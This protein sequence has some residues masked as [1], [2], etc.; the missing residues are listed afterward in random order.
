M[1][2]ENLDQLS[3]STGFFQNINA[4]SPMVTEISLVKG[5]Q[6]FIIF[7]K[8]FLKSKVYF[9]SFLGS[10]G[11]ILQLLEF[12]LEWYKNGLHTMHFYRDIAVLSRLFIRKCQ[13]CVAGCQLSKKM[14][15][16]IGKPRLAFRIDRFLP[17]YQRCISNGY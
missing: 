17:K 15:Y 14:K 11:I 1:K 8:V 5:K 2:L 6:A 16:E 12:S 3:V 9:W 10:D 4:V 7:K 13:Q